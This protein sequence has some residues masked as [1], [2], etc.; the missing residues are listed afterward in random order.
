MLGLPREAARNF[1]NVKQ[2]Q[3]RSGQYSL[4]IRDRWQLRPD[5]TLTYGTR[6]EYYPFPVTAEQRA[7]TLRH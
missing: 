7:G 5:L 3:T 4:Y 6:W 1:L 2:L